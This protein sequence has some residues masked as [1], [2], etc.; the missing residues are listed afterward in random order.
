MTVLVTPGALA[1]LLEPVLDHGLIG[2]DVD[3]V[4]APLV[5]HADQSQLSP[6]IAAALDRLVESVPVIILSGRSI[7]SLERLFRFAPSIHVVGSHGLEVRG[8]A[9]VALGHDERRILEQLLALGD[10]AVDAIGEGAWLEHKPAS[11]VV[12]TRAADQRLTQPAVDAL[13]DLAG[14]VPGASVKY[15]HCVVEM[16]ARSA[17]KGSA[18]L[19]F[20]RSI[21]R[22]PVAYLGDDV[23]DEDAFLLMSHE[24]VSVRVGPGNTAA[25]FRLADTAAVAELLERLVPS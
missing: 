1:D 2:F 9:A 17:S 4:L 15:G 20:A 7:E 10:K 23:T 19:E 24:D 14:K 3:G 6:G 12:H 22:S 11:V 13:V 8:A 21:D 25:R 5:E 18:L 16:L